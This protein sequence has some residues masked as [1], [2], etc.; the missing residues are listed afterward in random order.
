MMTITRDSTDTEQYGSRQVPFQVDTQHI[1]ALLCF[2]MTNITT[3][4]R[5]ALNRNLMMASVSLR[6]GTP[7]TIR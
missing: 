5:N 6:N 2:S 3:N 7:K 1:T 4:V